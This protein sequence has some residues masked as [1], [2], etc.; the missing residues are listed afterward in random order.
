MSYKI[1]RF[2]KVIVLLLASFA[3]FITAVFFTLIAPHRI[4]PILMYH[5]ISTVEQKKDILSINRGTFK[6][7]MDYLLK[8]NYKV[9]PLH[10][11]INM[12]KEGKDIPHDWIVLTFDDGYSDFYKVAYPIIKDHKFNVT[13]FVIVNAIGKDSNYLS[14]YELNK[15]QEDGLI[16]IGSHSL[17]HRPLI[18]LSSQGARQEIL[19]SKLILE[20][21][22][23]RPVVT[24]S[25][26]FGA[27]NDLIKEIVKVDGYESTVGIAYKRGEF[28]DNDIYMLKRVFVSKASKYP[29][30]FRLMATG[31]YVPTRELILKILNIKTPRDVWAFKNI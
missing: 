4:T 18:L 6:K 7:Q 11:V 10:R 9:V 5:S 21:E 23:E 28:G 27:A 15:L 16:D 1:P 30:V 25:Y 8:H 20:K 2:I 12:M 17:T 22:L 19:N 26:P 31:Y 13:V 29:I 3:I 14:Y 24:F